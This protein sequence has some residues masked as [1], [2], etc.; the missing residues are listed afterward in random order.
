MLPACSS[1]TWPWYGASLMQTAPSSQMDFCYFPSPQ[2]RRCT[3]WQT[4]QYC[5]CPITYLIYTLPH[6]CTYHWDASC[7]RY[8]KSGHPCLAYVSSEKKASL[9]LLILA[10]GN[11]TLLDLL[12]QKFGCTCHLVNKKQ[13]K[14]EEIHLPDGARCFSDELLL[15]V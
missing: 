15:L 13:S 5:S 9:Y 4:L 14:D 2:L 10:Y 8:T 12:G 6:Q 11:Q 3:A 7:N 1:S